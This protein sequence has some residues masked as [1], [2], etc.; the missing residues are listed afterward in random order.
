SL[1]RGKRPH[2]A[3]RHRWTERKRRSSSTDRRRVS[4][5]W[6]RRFESAAMASEGARADPSWLAG[7]AFGAV[8]PNGAEAALKQI[9]RRTDLAWHEPPNHQDFA[10]GLPPWCE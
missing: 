7:R 1:P 10:E 6:R 3:R 2:I 4:N 5:P 8:L 9:A